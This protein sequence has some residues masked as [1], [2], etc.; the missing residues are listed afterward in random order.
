MTIPPGTRFISAPIWSSIGYSLPAALGAGLADPDVWPVVMVGDG[1]L[2]M[3]AAEF[4]TCV[5]YG[6]QPVVILLD[7]AGYTI[8]RL[9]D[10]PDAPY[11]DIARWRW[12]EVL[13]AMTPNDSVWTVDVHTAAELAAALAQVRTGERRAGVI[14]V[15]LSPEDAPPTLQTIA[16]ILKSKRAPARQEQVR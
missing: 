11:H 14:V 2:Q 12:A 9:L 13:A 16:S 5:R 7:N 4:G 6:V 3:T 1:A 8:E 10:V 15:H